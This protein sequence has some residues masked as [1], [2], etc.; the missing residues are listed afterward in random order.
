MAGGSGSARRKVA[1]EAAYM[2]YFGQEKEYKQ[3]KLRASQTLGV[4]VLPSNLEVALEL[5]VL[6]QEIEGEARTQR[7]I[8]MRTQAHNLMNA[9]NRF[10]PVLIGSVW[11]GTIRKGS[12]IDISAYHDNPNEVLYTLQSSGFR[13]LKAEPV[14][15][16]VNGKTCSSF[17]IYIQTPNCVAEVVVR[18]L[19]E[20]KQ[21]RT[22]EFFGG[23]IKGLNLNELEQ[24][25]K[26]NPS[27]RFLP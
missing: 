11:R 15:A 21:K 27:Q 23:E 26:N 1:R 13:V 24:L 7:L 19:Q 3:A 17:H 6:A 22:C 2:L 9:L 5:D 10:W 20:A 14:R 16:T 12:D 4:H 18:D 25:L 8:Q